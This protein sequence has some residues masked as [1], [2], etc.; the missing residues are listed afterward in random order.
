M[1]LGVLTGGG[2]APGLNA[3]IRAVVRTAV[4]GYRSDVF[5]IGRGFE[6]LLRPPELWAL[7]PAD[8]QGLVRRGGTILGCN[9]GNPFEQEAGADRSEE[10]LET[11]RWFGLD[12]LICIGGAGSLAIALRLHRMGAPIVCIPKTIENDLPGTAVTFGAMTAVESATSAIDML[13][14]TGETVHRTMILEVSG[15]ESGWIAVSA[16]LAGG[17]DVVLIPERPYRPEHVLE[18][19]EQRQEEGKKSTIVVVAEGARPVGVTRLPGEPEGAAARELAGRLGDTEHRVT[20][21]GPL[22]RGGDPT[23]KD[24]ILAGRFG[25]A[26]VRA[27]HEGQ[28]GRVVGIAGEDTCLVPL[29]EVVDVVRTL[30]ADGELMQTAAAMGISFG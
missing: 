25:A 7:A 6:G 26:A 20:V 14:T 9:R 12:A 30:D 4:H 24:R 28:L 16:G 19:I 1:N 8:V 2:D 13:Q 3:V 15:R 29:E 5:G 18:V 21:L 10:I 27:A 11:V 23:A 22:Q 17:A